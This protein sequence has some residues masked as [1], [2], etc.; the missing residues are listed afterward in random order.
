MPT[1]AAEPLREY[2]ARVFAG[3]GVPAG[4]AA[5]VAAHLVEANLLGHDSHG[6]IRVERYLEHLRAGRIVAGAT[7]RVVSEGAS[8]AVV[9]GG[10]NF[11]QVVARDTMAHAVAKARAAGV[12]VAVARRCG[13]VGRLGA[14]VEQGVAQGCVALAMVNNHGGGQVMAP[15]GGVARRLSPNPIAFAAPTGDADAPFVLDMTTSVVAEGK[16]R[17]ARNRGEAVPP[18]WIVDGE[19]RPATD[20]GAYYGPPPGA[21]LPLGGEALHKGFGLALLVEALAG[22]LS[23][24]G[25]SRADGASGGNGLF[26]LAID[27]TAFGEAG[28]FTGEFGAVLE[29]VRTPPLAPGVARVITAGEPERDARRARA[30]AGIAIDEATWGQ[31]VAAGRSAG[32]EP[33]ALG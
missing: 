30:A 18:G 29:Y 20:P 33:P 32:V 28:A 2:V 23:G 11:G 6:V 31:L 17:V 12:G 16:L 8:T 5:T 25:T 19:G 22:A 27:P 21:I 1:I 3:A 4:D 15:P 14:Y 26:T 10:W 24:A 13:H 7:P 9:D